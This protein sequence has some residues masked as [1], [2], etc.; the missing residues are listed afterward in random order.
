MGTRR[1]GAPQKEAGKMGKHVIDG[2]TAQNPREAFRAIIA[3][4]AYVKRCRDIGGEK[5]ARKEGKIVRY[6]RQLRTDMWPW[7]CE[8]WEGS[9]WHRQAFADDVRAHAEGG[10]VGVRIYEVDCDGVHAEQFRV[11]PAIPFAI[12]CF[13]TMRSVNAEVSFSYYFLA[14]DD[15]EALPDS[16][17]DTFAEAAG[18]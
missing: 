11:F 3:A 12:H 8:S 9:L 7:H 16:F 4:K 17:R 14:P 1:W 18:Y 10:R 15:A 5:L 6:L 2:L 13:L